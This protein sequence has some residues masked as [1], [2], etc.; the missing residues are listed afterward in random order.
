MSE[1]STEAERGFFLSFLFSLHNVRRTQV[2]IESSLTAGRPHYCK[3]FDKTLRAEVPVD[4]TRWGCGLSH[5]F[6][7]TPGRTDTDTAHHRAAGCTNNRFVFMQ[8][9]DS[10]KL[11]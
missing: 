2:V 11:R 5:S 8:T 1:V 10:T 6:H 7:G 9:I 3:L 4:A